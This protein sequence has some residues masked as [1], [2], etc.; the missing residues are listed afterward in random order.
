MMWTDR[1]NDNI[2]SV[3]LYGLPSLICTTLK[4]FPSLCL[5]YWNAV[6][7][8]CTINWF[9]TSSCHCKIICHNTTTLQMI[10]DCNHHLSKISC[11]W[12]DMHTTTCFFIF[13]RPDCTTSSSELMISSIWSSARTVCR[14]PCETKIMNRL[15]L[16][17][18]DTFLWTSQLLSWAGREK[19]VRSSCLPVKLHFPV[20][21]LTPQ[22]RSA[23]VMFGFLCFYMIF[24]L[25]LSARHLVVEV[26]RKKIMST[27]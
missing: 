1:S 27:G 22:C 26:D 13:C 25:N 12:K 19:K 6:T 24:T 3:I 8:V 17:S 2:H 20:Y 7:L 10:V 9:F 16:T 11:K 18:I 21:N 14:Q 15:L 4:Q 5:I 23:T